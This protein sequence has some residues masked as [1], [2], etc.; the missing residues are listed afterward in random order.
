MSDN[1]PVVV[2]A[3]RTPFGKEDGVFADVRPEDLSVPLIDQ[4]L[5]E[6]GLTGEDVD[7]LKWGCA[8][9]REEQGNNMARVIALMSE[10]GEDTPATTINRWC[11]S[12]AEAVINA[13]DAIRAGQRDCIIAG[14]VESMSMVKMG[15]NNKVHPGLNDHHNIAALQMGMTAEE[16]AERYDVSRETQDEY[17]ARSQQRAVEATEEGRFDDEIVPIEGHDD[18]GNEVLVE[19]DEGL[20][21]GTTAEKLS[22][23]PTVFKADGSV[24]PGNASQTT[25]GASALLVTSEAFAEEQGFEILAEIGNNAVAGVE[26]EVMG[27]GPIPACENLFERSGTSADDYD[28]VEL[29]EA[30]ASQTVYCQEQLGFDDEIFNVNGG[31]IAIGHPLGATGAR[32]PVTLIH[33]MRK[34]DDAELGLATE[35][36]GFGQGAAI[37]FELR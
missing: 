22:G 29:N 20:R 9:Q 13:A 23:L 8:Q 4:I 17:A 26:P 5:D 14:G 30:F 25:D 21:P 2:K 32:L 35:C 15:E 33:E 19:E 18:E 36:V 31:A 10:L 6:T 1:T 11:A 37:E 27:I 12:S 24:T 3:Y 28:L 16:V 34:R 7:D